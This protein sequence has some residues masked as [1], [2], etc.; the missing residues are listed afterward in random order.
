MVFYNYSNSF[1]M[2]F[3]SKQLFPVFLH[4]AQVPY[5][6][7]YQDFLAKRLLLLQVD[8]IQIDI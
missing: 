7:F 8:Q 6:K 4:E 1:L 3:D 5:H 2:S